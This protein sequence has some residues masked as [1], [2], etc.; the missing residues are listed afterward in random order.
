[1]DSKVPIAA[2]VAGVVGV[3]I[4]T[5]MA[6]SGPDREE[7]AAIVSE[8]LAESQAAPDPLEGRIEDLQASVDER[9]AELSGS[10]EPK[11]GDL[12]SSVAALQ[13][14]FSGLETTAQSLMDRSATDLETLRAQIDGVAST[15]GKTMSEAAA[16]QVAALQGQL[17]QLKGALAARQQAAAPAAA[18]AA[19]QAAAPVPR[20][21]A[22]AL[23][24]GMTAM[25]ADGALRV[26]VS[27]VS[28][29]DRTARLSVQGQ[30]ASMEVGDTMLTMAGNDYC[31]VTLDGIAAG[32]AQIS[33]ACGDDL[34]AAT[35]AGPGNTVVLDGG[36]IRVFVSRVEDWPQRAR[37][38]INGEMK[39]L[40]P[41][42]TAL[43]AVGDKLCGVRLDAVD[44]GHASVSAACGA[45]LSVAEAIGPG[46]AVSLGD[47]KARVFLSSVA[48]DGSAVRVSVNGVD[49]LQTVPDGGRLALEDGCAVV[50]EGV[51]GGK[52]IFGYSCGG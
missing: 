14:K 5:M 16:S 44:R 20:S 15:L 40:E 35:G 7:I 17:D 18:P 37:L 12:G 45:D 3:L 51:A 43:L 1:M 8:K 31:M 34:P 22:G 50:V 39:Q 4:G 21:A 36:D 24:P 49:G 9:F 28:G 25:L 33:G 48:E 30:L 27:R 2:A 13:E 6:P 52:A 19:Q 38:S 23:T 11:M 10:M 42:R 46:S 32:G 47:G 41:G 26:F 29:E